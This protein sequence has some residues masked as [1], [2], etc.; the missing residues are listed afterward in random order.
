MLAV[1]APAAAA[2]SWRQIADGHTTGAPGTRTV[3]YVALS[4]ADTAAFASRIGAGASKLA[5]VNWAKTAVVAVLADWGCSDG[6]VSIGNVTQKGSKLH[7][8]LVHGEPPAGTATCQ[9]LFG[10]YRL[11]TVPKSA[12][13]KP[14]PTSTVIDVA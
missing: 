1:G 3:A 6:M 4:R 11:L 2:D 12:L 5:H 8:L 10:V 9:A 14:Y 13:H 7:V